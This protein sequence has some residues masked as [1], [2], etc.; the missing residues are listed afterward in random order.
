M[1]IVLVGVPGS[2][3]S[4]QAKCLQNEL[5]IPYV[6]AGGLL[7]QEV[8][9]GSVLGK[10]LDIL[11]SQGK[12]APTSLMLTIFEQR[13]QKHDVQNGAILDGFPR[14]LEQAVW[15]DTFLPTIQKRVDAVV[16]ITIPY[17][18]LVDRIV[19]RQINVATGEIHHKEYNPAPA[20][21]ELVQRKDDRKDVVDQRYAIYRK[22]TQPLVDHYQKQGLVATVSGVGSVN[23]T[24]QRILRV[25]P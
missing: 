2:G 8:Q 6:S 21:A 14:T 4:T 16:E 18:Y 7:R 10:K 20:G 12:F 5:N 25:L 13:L 23:E 24:T 1:I 17:E 22:K 15:F 9:S 3:K 19:G 11:L